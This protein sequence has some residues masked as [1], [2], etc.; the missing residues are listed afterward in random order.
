MFERLPLHLIIV[1]AILKVIKTP[2]FQAMTW[3]MTLRFTE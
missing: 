1:T 3:N 2:M